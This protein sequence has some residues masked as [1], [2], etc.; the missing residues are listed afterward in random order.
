MKRRF[1]VV[2]HGVSPDLKRIHP[3]FGRIN[4][5]D[6][7]GAVLVQVLENYRQ[8][9]NEWGAFISRLEVEAEMGRFV[10]RSA[11]KQLTLAMADPG[12]APA[13]PLTVEQI[14]AR[15]E[16]LP[17]ISVAPV[18]PPPEPVWRSVATI[19]LLCAGLALGMLAL[20]R[21]S[22]PAAADQMTAVMLVTDVAEAAARQQAIIG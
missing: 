13:A 1:P 16:Q 10:I 15:L 8:L 17:V 9:E 5:G 3:D 12:A 19:V 22:E 7:S 14:M 2:T 11:D 21:K 18:R 6:V 20:Q 4:R